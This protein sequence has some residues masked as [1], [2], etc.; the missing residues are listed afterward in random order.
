MGHVDI[1][2]YIYIYICLFNHCSHCLSHCNFHDMTYKKNVEPCKMRNWIENELIELINSNQLRLLFPIQF[3]FKIIQFQFNSCW[4]ELNWLP[5]PIQFMT[6]SAPCMSPYGVIQWV[7]AS[8]FTSSSTVYSK[9]YW[10]WQQ[11]TVK[12]L[13]YWPFVGVIH[14]GLLTQKANNMGTFQIHTKI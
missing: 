3:Q 2:I 8:H 10:S 6:W 13:Q 7:K 14:W 11:N 5:I 1:Y 9:S 4:I 12:A